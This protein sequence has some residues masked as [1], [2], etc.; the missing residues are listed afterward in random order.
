VSRLPSVLM[1]S[2]PVAPPWN[3]S[4]KNLVK[5]LALAG[6]DFSYNVLTPHDEPLQGVGIESEGIYPGGGAHTPALKQNLRVLGRLL[7]KD[8]SS[9][10]HFFFA[11]N[12][13][14]S[15]AARATLFVRPRLTVQT[16]CSTPK[17]FD[18]IHR[19][20][21]AERLVTL[22]RHTR[23]LLVGA[24]IAPPRIRSIAPG[25][26]M[27]E[28]PSGEKRQ[29]LRQKFD[30][31]QDHR[32]VIFPGDY[33]FSSAAQTVADATP[34][35]VDKPTTVI[36]ACRIKQEASKVIEKEIDASLRQMGVR[37]SV[38]MLNQVDDILDLLGACDICVL[39]AESLYAKMDIPLVLIEALALGLPIVVANVPPLNEVLV[40]EVGRA[41]PPKDPQA[42]AAAID[43][44]TSMH[45][46]AAQQF[47][48][49]CIETARTH[50]DISTVSRQHEALYTEMLETLSL[51]HRIRR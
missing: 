14:T 23:D 6:S 51:P 7:R 33:Q 38:K 19:L 25:I 28:R 41:V 43:A 34:L 13:K 30:L 1:I 4:S 22:S 35:L 49:H 12:A 18:K 15:A 39:P 32:V 48:A 37:S 11:P 31:P 44:L 42:L 40:A 24:G 36:F 29:H 26:Q 46:E 2:K 5:D 10:T 27:P 8:R 21:F 16:I 45:T 3:D 47:S 50:F 20:L 17:S 9:L